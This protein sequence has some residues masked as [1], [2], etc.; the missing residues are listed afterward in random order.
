MSSGLFEPLR[1]N[2]GVRLS[3]WYA[4]VFSLS[5]AAV[6]TVAYYVLVAATANKDRE[7][8][9]ARLKEVAVVYQA[10]G[11]TGLERWV[12]SQP[13]QVQNTMFVRLVN[14]YNEVAFASA[15]QDWV[16][17]HDAPSG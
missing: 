16:D 7:V 15:P 1:R 5:S 11:V 12:R 3:L 6:F 14:A 10:R 17:Y 2:I 13:A 4:L 9:E 8:L